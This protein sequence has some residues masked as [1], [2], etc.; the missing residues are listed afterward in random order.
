MSFTVG[1]VCTGNLCRSPAAEL[2][3]RASL[4]DRSAVRLWSAGTYARPGQPL[5]PP[6][7]RVLA[8]WRIDPT[9]HRASRLSADLLA[10]ADLVLCATMEHRDAV[11]ALAPRLMRRTFTIAEFAQLS[12]RAGRPAGGPPIPAGAAG[13]DARRAIVSAVAEQ[14]GLTAPGGP[15]S[16]DIRDPLGLPPPEV[17]AV[18]EHIGRL[19]AQIAA[20]LRLAPLAPPAAPPA[21]PVAQLPPARPPTPPAAPPTPAAPGAAPPAW[22][23]T[24]RVRAGSIRAPAPPN[25]P[26]W[27][28]PTRP[29]APTA[30][31]EPAAGTH[32]RQR[33][34]LA[35]Q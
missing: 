7:A 26:T 13:D 18:L 34:R 11:L 28:P 25:P 16:Y 4:D 22:G 30:R 10:D 19:C 33:Q 32:D 8:E 14:R 20:T 24:T 2:L 35:A 17:R 6:C 9:A 31:P 3:L 5:D 21:P 12:A 29:A 23:P 1:F 27:V 15:D